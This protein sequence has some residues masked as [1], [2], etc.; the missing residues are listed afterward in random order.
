MV[1]GGVS[2]A[3]EKLFRIIFYLKTTRGFFLFFVFFF[4]KA[5][6]ESAVEG[7]FFCISS[8]HLKKY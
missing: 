6:T 3:T 1:R 7:T 2:M 5:P 4:L 8:I